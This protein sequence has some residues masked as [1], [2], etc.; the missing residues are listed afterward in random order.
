MRITKVSNAP[1]FVEGII[2]LRGKVTPVIDMRKRF[3]LT[4][5]DRNSQTRIKVMG[6][7]E[8]TVVFVVDA[9]CEVLR[10]EF[11]TVEP[12]PDVVSGVG[13]EYL[14]RVANWKVFF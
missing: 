1:P 9:V 13:S 6:L 11:S 10:I 5:T 2:I 4:T 3:G 14:R 8:R 7:G 12:P